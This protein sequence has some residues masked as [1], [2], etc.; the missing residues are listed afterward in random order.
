MYSVLVRLLSNLNYVFPLSECALI[1][2]NVAGVWFSHIPTLPDS[3]HGN[4]Q[5]EQDMI[6]LKY[7]QEKVI[8]HYVRYALVS[9]FSCLHFG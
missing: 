1:C 7:L 4:S 6:K 9:L 2:R 8:K 5:R 3:N